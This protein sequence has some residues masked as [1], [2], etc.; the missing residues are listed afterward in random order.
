MAGQQI[1]CLICV[2]KHGR[3]YEC[4]RTMFLGGPSGKD[5]NCHICE[6][7]IPPDTQYVWMN[8]EFVEAA[9]KVNASFL[10]KGKKN[11]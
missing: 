1:V 8:N 5:F 7:P 4:S 10:R 9:K 2:D 11:V 6:D 3:D